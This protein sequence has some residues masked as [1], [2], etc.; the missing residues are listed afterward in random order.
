[1]NR[2]LLITFWVAAL[3]MPAL[4]QRTRRPATTTAPPDGSQTRPVVS[5]VHVGLVYVLQTI[6]LK[7]E[8]GGEEQLMTLDGEPAPPLRTK[9]V[10]VGL[11]IDNEGHIVTR[12]AA[13][14]I[15]SSGARD[16]V[17]NEILIRTERASRPYKAQF[18]GM[19]SATGLCLLQTDAGAAQTLQQAEFESPSAKPLTESNSREVQVWGFHPRQGQGQGQSGPLAM[20]VF[21][22]INEAQGRIVKATHDFR[23]SA[24]NSLYYLLAPQLSAVQDGSLVVADGAVFGIAVFETGGKGYNLIYPISRVR[25][26]A[27]TLAKSKTNLA[28]GWLGAMGVDMYTPIKAGAAPAPVTTDLG[29]R[30]TAVIPDSPADKAGVR[31]QDILLAV[32]DHAVGSVAQLTSALRQIPG[33]CEVTLKIKRRGEY[34]F[35]QAT[36]SPAPAMDDRQQVA[37]LAKRLDGLETELGSLQQNDP[38]RHELEPKVTTMRTIMDGLLSPA[39]AEV[40]LRVLF[41]LEVQPLTEQLAK[42]FSVPNG[43]LTS[44]VLDSNRSARAGLKPGDIIVKAGDREVSDAASLL[45]ILEESKSGSVDLLISRHGEQSRVQISR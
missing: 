40:K 45:K 11:V 15:S 6:D 27:E 9:N 32:N 10:T 23:Y 18:I 30:V 39:P 2:T 14:P 42:Y 21:P 41:G 43:L 36:L 34:K 4:A 33:D 29:V 19:D 1:M 26:L 24:Q 5:R 22:R 16:A 28:H 8:L 17:E 13:P 31:A 7:P 44:A 25:D 35:L 37:I 12:L 38:R 20:T 3:V